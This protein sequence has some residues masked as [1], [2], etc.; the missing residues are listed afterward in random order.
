M[1]RQHE[2]LATPWAAGVAGVVFAILMGAAIVLVR[3]ALPAGAEDGAITDAAQRSAVRTALELLPFAGIAFLW[4]MGALREQAGEGEDQFFSTVFLGSGL[5]FVATLFGAAAAAGTVVDESQQHPPFGRHFAY[6][7]L[8]TYAMRMAAVFII[9]ASTIG[10]RRG[11]LPRPL[12][13]L[14]YLAGLA[15]LVMGANVPW[16]ELV[17]P[18][19]ALLLS[20]NILR[21]RRP[22]RPRPAPST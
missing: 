19:W 9:T 10:R 5:V 1:E 15:L 11:T 13:V 12:V 8:T 16:S 14:G 18:A 22:V 7:L 20:L 4:F 17:F 6:A 3:I 21:N 2:R